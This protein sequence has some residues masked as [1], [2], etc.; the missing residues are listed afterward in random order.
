[1][2][3][4]KFLKFF[5]NNLWITG[6]ILLI[7]VG[8]SIY[9]VTLPD[10]T[11]LKLF[12]Y[13]LPFEKSK[14]MPVIFLVCGFFTNIFINLLTGLLQKDKSTDTNNNIP[15]IEIKNFVNTQAENKVLTVNDAEKGKFY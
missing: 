15:N 14:S 4:H 3:A 5:F 1:M 7:C 10:N 13:N 2:S 12:G 11:E 6:T 9:Y 8:L